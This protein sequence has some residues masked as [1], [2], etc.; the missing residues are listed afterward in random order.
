MTKERANEIQSLV[1]DKVYNNMPYDTID[2]VSA[3][4]AGRMIGMMQET[5]KKELEKEVDSET[6]QFAMWV[7]TEIFDDNWKYNKDAFAE[8]ACR[9]LAKMGI[10]EAKGG[11]WELIKSE[12]EDETE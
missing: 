8:L 6:E 2:P 7:A 3:F 11:E 4:L 10:V 9:R 12:S 1:N 5:L